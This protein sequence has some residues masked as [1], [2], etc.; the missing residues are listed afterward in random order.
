MTID[1]SQSGLTVDRES[2]VALNDQGVLRW[3]RLVED[4]GAEPVTNDIGY[5]GRWSP[6]GRSLI[7]RRAGEIVT[8][9]TGNG[10]NAFELVGVGAEHF[11]SIR[12]AWTAEAEGDIARA[13]GLLESSES[14][15]SAGRRYLQAGD[16]DSAARCY[17]SACQWHDAAEI[18]NSAGNSLQAAKCHERVSDWIPAAYAY[19]RANEHKDA[20]R[21]FELLQMWDRAAIHYE[22]CNEQSS[23]GRCLERMGA[24]LRAALAYRSAGERF[25][26]GACHDLAGESDAAA[27][28]RA[29]VELQ[30]KSARCYEAAE[31]WTQAAEGYRCAGRS[32]D[33]A[34][35]YEC[36]GSLQLAAEQFTLAE[37]LDDA[38][39][40]QAVDCRNRGDLVLACELFEQAAASAWWDAARN[41]LLSLLSECRRE[42][43][44]VSK[45]IN[46]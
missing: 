26:A 5:L 41:E 12:A 14:Y 16:L 11:E 46:R 44:E 31:A 23:L 4:A 39:R 32:L 17:E 43:S 18:H 45:A 22:A 28:D 1:D 37:C 25:K 38:L 30:L 36:G 6:L 24:F 27:A 40:C 3:F 33:A 20:G 2:L 19:E 34:H 15:G 13:A 8:I 10:A 35:A 7:G 21:M 42:L 29:E 9:R